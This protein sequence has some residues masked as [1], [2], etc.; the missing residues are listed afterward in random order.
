MSKNPN[1]PV[2]KSKFTT[3]DPQSPLH[4]IQLHARVRYQEVEKPVFN[5]VQQKLY[6]EIVYGLNFFNEEEK[7]ALPAKRRYR[8]MDAYKKAQR[9]LNGWKQQLVN[10]RADIIM[11]KLFPNSSITKAFYRTQGISHDYIDTHTFKELG[12]NQTMIAEKLVE[13]RLLP[14]DFFELA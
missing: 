14:A 4:S 7:A 6:A 10:N 5:K 12:I 9:L 13:A 2:W 11:Q 3:Y 8:I 1:K